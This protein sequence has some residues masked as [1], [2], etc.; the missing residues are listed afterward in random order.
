MG[1]TFPIF[2]ILF[3]IFAKIMTLL[4][5]FISNFPIQI[6]LFTLGMFTYKSALYTNC[7]LT[8]IGSI[9]IYIFY[10]LAGCYYVLSDW[11]TC[12]SVTEAT[13][14]LYLTTL[15]I[16]GLPFLYSIRATGR[17]GDKYD[18]RS[19]SAHFTCTYLGVDRKIINNRSCQFDR[20]YCDVYYW[21]LLFTF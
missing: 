12:C 20:D 2:R 6:S 13:L 5:T 19:P 14:P 3:N 11:F 7:T 9:H 16:I 21:T 15:L 18:A 1:F 17:S 8:T 10:M 4:L